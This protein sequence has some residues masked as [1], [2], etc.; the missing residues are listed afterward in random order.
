[1][2]SDI[3]LDLVSIAGLALSLLAALLMLLLGH[4][5]SLRERDQ[6]LH[7][8]KLTEREAQPGSFP[9][10]AGQAVVDVDAVGSDT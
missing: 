9:V 10:G 6:Q 3:W 1:M 2:G 4:R 5:S 7:I 8:M